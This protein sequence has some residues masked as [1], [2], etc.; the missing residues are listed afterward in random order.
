MSVR[1]YKPE[2]V[3]AYIHVRQPTYIIVQFSFLFFFFWGEWGYHNNL[4]GTVKITH[5]Q[6]QIE[7]TEITPWNKT[8]SNV[9]MYSNIESPSHIKG[10]FFAYQFSQS[11]FIFVRVIPHTFW[12]MMF[13]LFLMILLITP[14]PLPLV[15]PDRDYT[16]LMQSLH[17][18]FHAWVTACHYLYLQ[19]FSS[20]LKKIICTHL[21]AKQDLSLLLQQV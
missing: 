21:A 4:Q 8:I 9:Y 14:Y 1:M 16:K 12:Y 3:T 18:L 6:H 7:G 20:H 13:E 15:L 10:N 19:Q 17:C 11:L 5:F 2:D